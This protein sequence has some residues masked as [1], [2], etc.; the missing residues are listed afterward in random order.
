M[1]GVSYLVDDA[2]KKTAVILDLRQ[3]IEGQLYRS[4]SRRAASTSCFSFR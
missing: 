4:R 2:G 1:K 3:H